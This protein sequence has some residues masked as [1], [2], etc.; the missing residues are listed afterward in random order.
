MGLREL[1]PTDCVLRKSDNSDAES[2]SETSTDDL[3]A[4]ES[5]TEAANQAKFLCSLF[6]RFGTTTTRVLRIPAGPIRRELSLIPMEPKQL[7]TVSERWHVRRFILR[8]RLL[9]ARISML[10]PQCGL[11]LVPEHGAQ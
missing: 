1:W 8:N 10:R 7:T 4:R 9:P 2:E 3:T 6:A 11:G 5:L